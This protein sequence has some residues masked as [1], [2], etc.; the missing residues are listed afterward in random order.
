MNQDDW[1][2]VG[3]KEAQA[4]HG[5][6]MSEMEV[7]DQY[8]EIKARPIGNVAPYVAP[9]N[10]QTDNGQL[11]PAQKR[12]LKMFSIAAPITG[13]SIG[14]T[15][16]LMTGALNSVLGWCIGGGFAASVLSGLFGGG[17]K[18][19][20]EY[21]GRNEY[22]EHHHYHQNNNFG[23]AGGANQNNGNGT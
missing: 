9:E 15:H 10:T 3:L 8:R 16:V 20:A 21:Q 12:G 1:T 5:G 4:R 11:T 6:G 2:A 14:L 19:S 13:I 18:R 7:Y 23:G 17:S 22:H